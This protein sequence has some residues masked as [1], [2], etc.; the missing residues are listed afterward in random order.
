M[1]VF[2]ALNAWSQTPFQRFYFP[3]FFINLVYQLSL[4]LNSVVFPLSTCLLS[5]NHLAG[6]WST[7]LGWPTLWPCFGGCG[8]R[9]WAIRGK[10]RRGENAQTP[11]KGH[12][13]LPLCASASPGFCGLVF[14]NLGLLGAYG[15]P[16]WSALYLLLSVLLHICCLLYIQN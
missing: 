11:G 8:C 1:K 13:C 14:L 7:L 16:M 10:G 3:F 2:I 12:G 9:K 5:A 15:Q 6:G 4:S